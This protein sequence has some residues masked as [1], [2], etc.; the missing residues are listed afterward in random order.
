MLILWLPALSDCLQFSQS[1][2]VEGLNPR[3]EIY[4][5]LGNIYIVRKLLSA[6]PLQHNRGGKKQVSFFWLKSGLLLV[7]RKGQ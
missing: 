7:T 1:F 2:G 3:V 6:C 4:F 5:V